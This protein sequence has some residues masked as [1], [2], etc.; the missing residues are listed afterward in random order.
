MNQIGDELE[1]DWETDTRDKGDHLNYSG[2]EKASAY[3][4]Q[5]L[6]DEFQLTD[7]RDD[8][9]YHS[10]NDSL[11]RYLKKVERLK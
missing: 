5:W 10:W 6:K 4:G 11:Q 9:A 7:H 2:A 8:D 3:L 1:I